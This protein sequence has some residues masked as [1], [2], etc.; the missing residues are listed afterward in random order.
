MKL[1]LV[2]VRRRGDVS[3]RI[4]AFDNL[5]TLIRDV[6]VCK[7][8]DASVIWSTLRRRVVVVQTLGKIVA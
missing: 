3:A 2:L 8:S 4:G 5:R 7:Y 6:G 1:I